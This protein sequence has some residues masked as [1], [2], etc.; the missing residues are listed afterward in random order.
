MPVIEEVSALR[1]EI[2]DLL[3]QQMAFVE[4]STGFIGRRTNRL[5]SQTRTS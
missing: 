1:R 4:F 3:N 2:L 5:L